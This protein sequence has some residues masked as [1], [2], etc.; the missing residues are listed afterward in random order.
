MGFMFEEWV[1]KQC[2]L[3]ALMLDNYY[4]HTKK[5]FH[6]TAVSVTGLVF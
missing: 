4:M 3:S 6:Q 2:Q 1:Q 5:L